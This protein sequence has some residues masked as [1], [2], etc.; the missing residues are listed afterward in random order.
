MNNKTEIYYESV[1]CIDSV[2]VSRSR[3]KRRRPPVAILVELN[4]VPFISKQAREATD[5]ADI[6]A[7]EDADASEETAPGHATN[8]PAPCVAKRGERR[9]DGPI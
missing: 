7:S 1:F 3:R 9:C 8:L 4:L 5:V 6:E 2:R